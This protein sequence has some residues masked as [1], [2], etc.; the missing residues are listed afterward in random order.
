MVME[1]VHKHSI[2]GGKDCPAENAQDRVRP[3]FRGRAVSRGTNTRRT[4]AH[5]SS[6]AMQRSSYPHLTLD[7]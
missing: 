7:I 5:Q 1:A 6:S 2:I 3:G 4:A